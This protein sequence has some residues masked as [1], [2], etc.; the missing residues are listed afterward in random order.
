MAMVYILNLSISDVAIGI[1]MVVLKSLDPFMKTTLKGNIIAIEFYHVIRFCFIRL[2]LFVSVFNLIALTLDRM[3]AITKPFS[4]RKRRRKFAINVCVGVWALSIAC[5]TLVY[6][7]SRF[8]LNNIG[9]YNNL[10]F[11]V[12]TYSS[13][14][15]FII[16]YLAI[17][18]SLRESSKNVKKSTD[19]CDT[20]GDKPGQSVGKKVAKR[21]NNNEV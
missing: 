16:S 15:L 9:R 8:H 19:D 7:I 10:V 14:I 21:T 3:W 20:A 13:T 12:A 5:V 2:S 4:H 1:V 6:C 18:H 11:P 17:F